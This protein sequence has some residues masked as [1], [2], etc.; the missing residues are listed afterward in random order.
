MP[1]GRDVKKTYKLKLI[2]SRPVEH[3]KIRWMD[4]VMKDIQA[5]NIVNWKSYSQYKI[6]GSQLLSKPKPM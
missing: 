1:D 3:P 2:A 5:I 4:S 6:N